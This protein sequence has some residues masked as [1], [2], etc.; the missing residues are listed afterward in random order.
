[1][2]ENSLIE[3][4]NSEFG[5]DFPVSSE[6]HLI[7]SLT[8]FINEMITTDFQKLVAILYKVDV[9]ENKLK[10]MLLENAGEN[11]PRIIATLII[12]RQLQKIETR[13]KFKDRPFSDEEEKWQS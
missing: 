13:A 4:L 10:Q 8:S 6:Q 9:N 5:A 1:M 7:E 12:E 2:I 11:A 3:I